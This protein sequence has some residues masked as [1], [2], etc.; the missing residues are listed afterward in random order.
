M[1]LALYVFREWLRS[2]AVALLTILGVFF[3]EHVHR[4]LPDLLR[5]GAGIGRLLGIYGFLLPGLLPIALPIALLLSVLFT[6]GK[7]HGSGEIVAMRISGASI[8]S[9]TRHL[10]SGG[11][12]LSFL[13]FFLSGTAIPWAEERLRNAVFSVKSGHL[14][15][16]KR[17]AGPRNVA[18]DNRMDG[19]LWHIGALDPIRKEARQMNIYTYDSEGNG[20]SRIGA[21]TGHYVDGHWRLFGGGEVD[22][23]PMDSGAPAEVFVEKDFFD[24]WEP[25]ELLCLSQRR[26]RDLSLA[27]VRKILACLPETDVLLTGYKIRYHLLFAGCWSPIVILFCAIP[28]SISGVGKGP[29]VG[30]S[31]AII[32]IFSFYVLS[33][34][35][36]IL[37]A[38]GR[39]SPI[40][41][42]WTPNAVLL[43]IGGRLLWKAR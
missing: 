35:C 13:L 15:P 20:L 18:Y 11:L 42:A 14:L 12:L 38:G 22:L 37:G 23:V 7:L 2:M 36:Q 3:L 24:F 9:F 5:C 16:G 39:L 33:N 28:F 32:L 29:A 6:L 43:A 31:R 1:T 25:C 26:T 17:S 10:W 34:L 21:E 40:F 30:I 19:R 41:A 8:F 4:E 27:M